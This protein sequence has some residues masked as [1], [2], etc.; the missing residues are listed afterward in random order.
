MY[1]IFPADEV[2]CQSYGRVIVVP[3]LRPPEYFKKTHIN[4]PLG[5][6]QQPT[7]CP[8]V[9][10]TSTGS[11]KSIRSITA[12]LFKINR[13]E[14]SSDK[15]KQG[16]NNLDKNKQGIN[17]ESGSRRSTKSSNSLNLQEISS[18]A[19]PVTISSQESGS[20]RSA[21]STDSS[22]GADSTVGLHRGGANVS[23]RLDKEERSRDKSKSPRET[24]VRPERK[25]EKNKLALQNNFDENLTNSQERKSS[26]TRSSTSSKSK[27]PREEIHL[28][29]SDFLPLQ[30]ERNYYKSTE[31]KGGSLKFPKSSENTNNKLKRNSIDF[32]E[33]FKQELQFDN[34]FVESDQEGD[35]SQLPKART[36]FP[37]SQRLPPA[38]GEEIIWLDLFL[39]L[40]VL[41]LT[42]FYDAFNFVSFVCCVLV[43]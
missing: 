19:R 28:S 22:L 11:S 31:T 1:V 5:S 29:F 27:T 26:L 43:R 3:P 14:N 7:T 35:K 42:R 2:V 33:L 13:T 32:E 9:P 41:I 15:N 4:E 25:K 40:T 23:F 38:T 36:L 39:F 24:P 18:F 10:S 37:E 8:S 16:E 21:R 30:R 6:N 12:S 20:R 34:E 17:P